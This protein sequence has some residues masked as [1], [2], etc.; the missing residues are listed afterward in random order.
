MQF[1]FEQIV[2]IARETVFRFF[3][4]SERLELLHA[5]WSRVRLVHHEK[6]VRVGAEI[7]V[8]VTVAGFIPMVL[9]FRHTLFEPPARFGEEAIHGPFSRFIH[10]HE[11]LARDGQTAVRDRLDVRLPWH[12]GG[13]RIMRHIVAPAIR[14]MFQCRAQAL[15]RLASHGTLTSCTSRSVPLPN[16]I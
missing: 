13:E 14:R 9:G 1:C 6:L 10:I 15:T 16:Q 8:E 11:F 5:G 7:W 4:N 12:Y 3:Q 2:P